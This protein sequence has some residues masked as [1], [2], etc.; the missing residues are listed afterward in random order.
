MPANQALERLLEPA[1]TAQGCYLE[2]VISRTAGKRRLVRVVVDHPG[3][4]PLDLVAQVS[5]AVSRALDESDLLG[6]G[7]YVLEV[8]SP[9]VDRPL[10]LPRHWEHNLGRLVELS[11]LAG[12]LITGRITGADQLGAELDV[13]GRSRRVA[14]ADVRRAVVQ[15]EFS[16]MAAVDLGDDAEQSDLAEF[17]GENPGTDEP[18][19]EDE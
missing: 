7:P 14:F 11:T 16:R 5:R 2:A 12:E 4:L 17:V 1:V 6:D 8:T 13:A 15:V 19:S 10:T 9:G 18:D 3:G